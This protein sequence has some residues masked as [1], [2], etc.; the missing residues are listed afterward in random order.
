M[1]TPDSYLFG[2]KAIS[3][4]STNLRNSIWTILISWMLI[5]VSFRLIVH[6]PLLLR[7]RVRFILGVATPLVNWATATRESENCPH[8]F[9]L[10]REK[11][12][13]SFQL[14]TIM[15]L[16]LVGM[17]HKKSN[18]KRNLKEKC[19]KSKKKRKN[20]RKKQLDCNRMRIK[21]QRT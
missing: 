3:A 7:S 6:L 2:A 11:R 9:N 17:F 5:L 1:L 18:R 8:K 14:G 10:W 15:S 21:D 12:S 20:S 16:C 4:F 13:L 19:R